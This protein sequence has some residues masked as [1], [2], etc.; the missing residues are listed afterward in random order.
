[1]VK[2]VSKLEDKEAI[3]ARQIMSDA[4]NHCSGLAKELHMHFPFGAFSHYV[5]NPEFEHFIKKITANNKLVMQTLKHEPIESFTIRGIK[6]PGVLKVIMLLP[7]VVKKFFLGDLY[8]QYYRNETRALKLLNGSCAP[9]L[10]A[11]DCIDG[12]GVIVCER[13]SGTN[14]LDQRTTNNPWHILE[15]KLNQVFLTLHQ[16]HLCHGDISCENMMQTDLGD[17]KLLDFEFS[18]CFDG[19]QCLDQKNITQL[20][21]QLWRRY[22]NCPL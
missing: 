15:E 3:F 19:H 4:I 14:L 8:D 18:S 17:F 12:V 22:A 13:L 9:K 2:L 6:K 16:H 1:M 7:G 11:S 21:E 5:S 10:L 20:F